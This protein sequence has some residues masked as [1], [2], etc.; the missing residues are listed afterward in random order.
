M[1]GSAGVVSRDEDLGEAIYKKERNKVTDFKVYE[2]SQFPACLSIGCFIQ[3]EFSGLSAGEIPS[4]S[5]NSLVLT[6]R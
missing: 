5:G 2:F 1:S 3:C 4:S 6:V